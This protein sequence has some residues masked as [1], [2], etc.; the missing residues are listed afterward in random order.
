MTKTIIVAQGMCSPIRGKLLTLFQP[1]GFKN[2]RVKGFSVSPAGY[3]RDGA[4]FAAGLPVLWNIGE[5]TVSDASAKWAEY[6]ICRSRQFRLMSTPLD[7]RNE[8]WASRYETLPRAWTQ[9]GCKRPKAA[10]ATPARAAPRP[11]RAGGWRAWLGW[12]LS[13]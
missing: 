1:Y 7:P 9:T 5:V 4:T 11:K 13:A 8:V 3:G 10:G 12:L 2:I 6:L